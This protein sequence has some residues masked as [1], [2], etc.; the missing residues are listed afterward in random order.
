[1]ASLAAQ[2]CLRINLQPARAPGTKLPTIY[3]TPTPQKPRD[4]STSGRFVHLASRSIIPTHF[5]QESLKNHDQARVD[6][7]SFKNIRKLTVHLSNQMLHLSRTVRGRW[8]SKTKLTWGNKQS[9]NA[10]L[11]QLQRLLSPRR[12]IQKSQTVTQFTFAFVYSVFA[13]LVCRE[14]FASILVQISAFTRW[15]VT[16]SRRSNGWNYNF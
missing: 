9:S 14:N 10:G 3:S 4:T 13:S 6:L 1:M 15:L 7:P 12:V 11:N 8:R 16:S 2:K 5:H